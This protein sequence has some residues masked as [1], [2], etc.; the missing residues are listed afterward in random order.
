MFMAMSLR[1]GKGRVLLLALEFLLVRGISVLGFLLVI[2]VFV[3]A[4]L[5]IWARKEDKVNYPIGLPINPA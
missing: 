2:G 5:P 4:S 1:M 3:V